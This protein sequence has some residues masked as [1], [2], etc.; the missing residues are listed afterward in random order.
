M[1]GSAT[2]MSYRAH[3]LEREKGASAGLLTPFLLLQNTS[4]TTKT[5]M[6]CAL[7]CH[8]HTEAALAKPKGGF[9]FHL[10]LIE[11]VSD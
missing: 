8:V 7:K 11:N 10:L 5:W 6:V 2:A 9:E 4:G 1:K 3:V